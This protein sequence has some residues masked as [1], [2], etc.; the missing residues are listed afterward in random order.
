MS[1][2]KQIKTWFLI[3]KWT[4]LICTVF[5]LMLCLTGLPLI[6]HEEIEALE[7]RPPLAPPMPAG[8]PTVALERLAGTVRQQYPTKVI[9]FVYWDEHEPNTTTFTLSDSM[10]APADNYK[11]VIFDNRTAR[12]LEEPKVQEGFMYVM[13]QL[14]V[15]M[16]MGIGGKLFL[17]LMGLLF[18]VAIGSGLML[19]SPI[20]RRFNFGMIRTEKATRL[21]WLDLHN[22]LG[23]VTVVWATVVGFTGVVNTLA[24]VVQG[25]WQQGQLAEMI[26]PYK[27]A[28]PVRGTLSPLDQAL[29][30]A[31]QAAPTM[32]PSFVAYPGTLYSSQHHYAVFMKGNTPLT[33]RMAKPAL[34]DA[35]TGQLTDMRSMPWYVNAVFISQPL[36]FGDYGG[37]PLKII[38]ALFDLITIVV[39]ISGLYLW[40][41]RNRAVNAQA[42][43]LTLAAGQSLEDSGILTLT[44]RKG[45]AQDV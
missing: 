40:F 24:E 20:M 29:K 16:F 15:D 5:L 23:V 6:F 10:T 33:S 7:G 41:A 13:L 43:R 45:A 4:S 8:T 39:L 12:V 2:T 27:G 22:L 35:K 14:H 32:E 36:H 34:I 38:W 11:L 44:L 25:M 3:H 37:L 31:R 9:R 18:V 28:A 30:V 1:T 21:K 42:K 19:Y 26:A 17:G